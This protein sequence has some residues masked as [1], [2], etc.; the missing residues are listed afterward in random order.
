MHTHKHSLSGQQE[1]LEPATNA[2]VLCS[3]AY[4][5][6]V[7]VCVCIPVLAVLPI[8][9]VSTVTDVSMGGAGLPV[10]LSLVLTWIQMASVC[11]AFPIVA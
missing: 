11:A 5:V 10:A 2:Q 4:C 8:V 1:V 7:G 3:S 6:C 9:V